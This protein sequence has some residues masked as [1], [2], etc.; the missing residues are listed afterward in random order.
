[1]PVDD[2]TERD[3]AASYRSAKQPSFIL[4]YHSLDESG[5]PISVPPAIFQQQMEFL[6][7][8]GAPVVPLRE[9][10]KQPGSVAITFDDGFDN[11]LTG[12]L[13]VL[14]RLQL[15]ATV[16]AV[17][18]YCGRRNDWPSQAPGIPILQLM[19]WSALRE[20]SRHGIEIGAHTIHHPR[21]TDLS[22]DEM[23]QE[24]NGCQSEIEDRIG[25]PV[26]SF[27][28]PYGDSNAQARQVARQHFDVAC[29]VRLDYAKAGNDML[30][31]PRLDAYYFQDPFWFKRMVTPVGGIYV[32]ARRQLRGLRT[33]M[34]G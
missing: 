29:G 3:P 11:F 21:M 20:I 5:S 31:L 19:N 14:H 10:F 23:E 6:S 15:P 34:L 1:M 33:A 25:K 22:S 28:Y 7:E 8:Y 27:A 4:T 18:G 16:F 9:I 26:R 32:W 17:S 13:P 2:S 24:V 12:A 30:D